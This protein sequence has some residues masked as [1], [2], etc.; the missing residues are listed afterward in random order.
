MSVNLKEK[1]SETAQ[2]AGRQVLFEDDKTRITYWRF[3][4]G[5]ETGWH[6]H[7]HDYVTIQ[8]SGGQL[9]LENRDGSIKIVDYE[10]GRA[11]KY[12]APIEHNAT[13]TSDVEVRVTEIEYKS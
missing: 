6:R 8:Q 4:P 9:R 12:E 1:S 7:T 3:D 5:A 11:A 10:N 13:N 2:Q